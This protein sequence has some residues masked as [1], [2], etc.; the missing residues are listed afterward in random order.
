MLKV[1]SFM[2]KN[3]ND[4]YFVFLSLIRTFDFVEGTLARKNANIFAFSLA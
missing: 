1:L 3:K 4:F 2:N